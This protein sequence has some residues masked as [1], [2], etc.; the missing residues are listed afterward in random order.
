[1]QW[2]GLVRSLTLFEPAMFHL[3]RD[4]HAI[5]R[6]MHEDIAVLERSLREAATDGRPEQG[7]ARFIDFWNGLGTFAVY[8]PERREKATQ[9]MPM[10]LANF[11]ALNQETWPLSDCA[12]A[13]CPTLGV[14]GENS[15][16][17]V[18]HLMRLIAGA[19]NDAKVVSV[20]A[21]GHMLP[22][23]HAET[24]AKILRSHILAAET[25]ASKPRAA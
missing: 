8:A 7:V 13:A 23:T 3:L 19:M 17:L 20:S 9:R 12:R 4:G 21:A 1:M 25:H 11:A 18:Q 15:P 6:Q 2:P 10:I 5:E 22:M 16:L 14:F 24:A